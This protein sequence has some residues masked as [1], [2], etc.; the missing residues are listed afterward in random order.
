[1]RIASLIP[2]GT[3]I[4]AAL[5]L[6][7]YLVG[8]SHCCDHP[9]AENLPVLTRSRIDPNLSPAEI[10]RAVNAAIAEDGNVSLYLTNRELLH[11]LHPDIVLTQ[12]ICDVC[13]VNANSAARDLPPGAKLVNLSAINFESLWDDLRCVANAGSTF[14]PELEVRAQALIAYGKSRLN[15]VKA[16]V[17][18]LPRPTVLVLEWIDPLFVGGHWVPEIIDVAAGEHL[19]GHAGEYSFRVTWD[20]VVKA[21]PDTIILAPCGYSLEDT[22]AAAESLRSN[23]EFMSMRGVQNGNLWAAD[24]THFFSRCTPLCVRTVEIVAGILHPEACLPPREDEALKITYE[25]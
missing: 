10:D 12:T 13:A 3:D 16:A 11:E 25:A 6:G 18:G 23:E 15:A 24:A 14:A 17:T 1:M 2:S 5:G 19:M 21:D 22:L 4:A 20:E 7:E 8:K 9:A